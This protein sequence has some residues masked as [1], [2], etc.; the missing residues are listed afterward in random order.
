[1]SREE[2]VVPFYDFNVRKHSSVESSVLSYSSINKDY[3]YKMKMKLSPKTTLYNSVNEVCIT[4]LEGKKSE[5]IDNSVDMIELQDLLKNIKSIN[6]NDF[7][8]LAFYSD[9]ESTLDELNSTSTDISNNIPIII[10]VNDINYLNNSNQLL[11][12]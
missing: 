4:L 12:N 3:I 1:M 2:R 5:I 9:Q 8:L 10:S 6:V 7:G 11:I